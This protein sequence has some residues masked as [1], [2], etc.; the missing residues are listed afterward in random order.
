[1]LVL[2]VDGRV[3]AFAADRYARLKA[4]SDEQLAAVRV[5]GDG[6]GLCWDALDATLAVSVVCREG[7]PELSDV[8]IPSHVRARLARAADA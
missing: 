8:A 6:D 5:Y 2:L 1:M 3:K 4:A 7:M